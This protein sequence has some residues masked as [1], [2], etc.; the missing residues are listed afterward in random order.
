MTL[1][2]V[3]QTRNQGFSDLACTKV[4]E[5]RQF[6]PESARLG[7]NGG[8]RQMQALPRNLSETRTNNIEQGKREDMKFKTSE[9][10]P[11]NITGRVDPNRYYTA[12]LPLPGTLPEKQEQPPTMMFAGRMRALPFTKN[13][14]R[15]NQSDRHSLPNI[16]S[17][18]GLKRN[19]FHSATAKLVILQKLKIKTSIAHI[20]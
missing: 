18:H 10:L 9:R 1:T 8:L 7:A 16:Y 13:G 6:Q 12:H 4:D 3:Y 15:K 14:P 17:Q 5:T 19:A 2:S 20:V 11:R